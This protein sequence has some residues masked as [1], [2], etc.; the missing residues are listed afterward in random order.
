MNMN[1]Q[2]EWDD[3]DDDNIIFFIHI[4]LY[5]VGSLYTFLY[6]Y[7]TVA[8]DFLNQQV[9]VSF[10]FMILKNLIYS[11]FIC[12]KKK[13]TSFFCYFPKMKT[14]IHFHNNGVYK[15]STGFAME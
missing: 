14:Y 7:V 12:L 1:H 2:R 15:C 13:N 11:L 8:R 5:I 4:I 9:S 10:Y 3:D 6:M